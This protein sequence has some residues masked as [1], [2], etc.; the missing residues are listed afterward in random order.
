M[1]VHVLLSTGRSDNNT[2]V[3]GVYDDIKKAQADMR[4]KWESSKRFW[5]NEDTSRF[6]EVHIELHNTYAEAYC[7]DDECEEVG[8]SWQI[9][10]WTVK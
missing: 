3:E 2:Q 9:E 7:S 4:E 1:Q 6:A 10:T 5:A 8:M